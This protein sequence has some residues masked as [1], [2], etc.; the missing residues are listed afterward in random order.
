[1]FTRYTVYVYSFGRHRTE[2]R[3]DAARS[4]APARYKRKHTVGHYS[5]RSVLDMCL[6]RVCP[7]VRMDI[8]TQ[9]VVDDHLSSLS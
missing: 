1:M 7:R 2:V 8:K 9:D 3:L 6:V 4:D 5:R